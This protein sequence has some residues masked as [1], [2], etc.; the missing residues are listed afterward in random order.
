MHD[1]LWRFRAPEQAFNYL[2]KCV[3]SLSSVKISVSQLIILHLAWLSCFMRLWMFSETDIWRHTNAV[4]HHHHQSGKWRFS[5][6]KL[7]WIFKLYFCPIYFF[8]C[9]K[10]I[11]EGR[12]HKNRERVEQMDKAIR[13]ANDLPPQEWHQEVRQR[14]VCRSKSRESIIFYIFTTLITLW[15]IMFSCISEGLW[16]LLCVSHLQAKKMKKLNS[17]CIWKIILI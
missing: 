12:E 9:S 17:N 15:N 2:P 13:D 16:N 11:N 1:F 5:R 14:Q 7:S 4:H 6:M 10:S 3:V 8:V